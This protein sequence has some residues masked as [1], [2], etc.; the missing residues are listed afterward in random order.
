MPEYLIQRKTKLDKRRDTVEVLTE[1]AKQGDF[2]SLLQLAI[3]H[4]DAAISE[5]INTW[6]EEAR[7]KIKSESRRTELNQV[8][9]SEIK[10][11]VGLIK[12]NQPDLI[13]RAKVELQ[14][15]AD[16]KIQEENVCRDVLLAEI[17]RRLR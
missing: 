1:F 4:E 10:R 9:K 16:R 12:S 15:F 2:S 6:E 8:E 14:A 3:L 7:N 5:A 11:L 17:A 13:D